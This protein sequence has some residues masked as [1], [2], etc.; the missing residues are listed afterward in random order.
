[1]RPAVLVAALVMAG[2]GSATGTGSKP[3]DTSGKLVVS[4]W[5]SGDKTGAGY[6][7]RRRRTRV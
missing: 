7:A 2:C 3:G 6:M 1:M 4:D 5:K